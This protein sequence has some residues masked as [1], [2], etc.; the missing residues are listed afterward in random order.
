MT[1][2]IRRH[3]LERRAYVYVRQSTP[4]QVRNHLEGKKLHYALAKRA[5]ELGFVKVAVIDED[6]G[7]SGGGMQERPG[8]GRL[9]A[10]VCQGLAGAVFALEAS[11][12]ARNNRDWHHLVDLCALT[13]TLLVD[14]EGIYDP[15]QLNDR[16]LLGLK[17]TMAEFE[18]GLLRQ[19]AREA[20]EQKARR[21]F[22][23]WQ[24]PVG[25][26]R[27]DGQRIEKTPDRQVQQAITS[28]FEKFRQLGSARQATIWFREENIPL[29]RTEPSTSGREVVWELPVSGRIRQILKNPCYAGTFAYGKT[30]SRTVIEEGRAR[31]GSRSRKPPE[32]WKVLIV[33]HHSGYISWEEYL[34]NQQRLEANVV[35]HEGQTG[36]AA[37]LGAALLSG[38]LRC[39]HCGRKLQVVYSGT[40]GRVPRYVCRGDRGDRGSSRCLT[41]GSLRIDRAVAESVLT[42]I[43]PAGIEAA[44][45][46]Q[47]QI[48]VDDGEKRKALELALERAGYEEKRARRQYDAVDPENRLVAGEL[49]AR[50]NRALAQAAEAEAKLAAVGTSATLLSDEQKQ[51]LMALSEDLLTLWNQPEAPVPLKKRIL[52]TVLKEVIVNA[53]GEAPAYRVRLHWEGGVHTEL[54]VERNKSGQNRRQVGQPVVELVGELAKVCPDKAIAAILNRLGYK[55]GHELTWNASRV[56]GLRGYHEIE[57]FRKQEDWVTQE[58]AAR[59]LQVSNTVVKRLIREQV[60]PAKQVVK[61]APWIIRKD[62]LNLPAVVVQVDAVRRGAYR[63]PLIAIGQGKLPLE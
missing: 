40:G 47:E 35:A 20:F 59:A 42:A 9:L 25:F 2:K 15:R 38:L 58:E 22:A 34:E 49:E 5:E 8:F 36:G 46:F 52:R 24:V 14:S 53:D 17:G 19:R 45:R 26:I 1:E 61:F 63:P 28:V 50:W 48:S 31:Q 41:L 32:E 16:L 18:I 39:G 62:A 55:T 57:P 12:L 7:R 21:G 56:A 13:E 54:C 60:L 23:L 30:A 44:T 27:T 10:S 43:Q 29:P 51:L 33:G 37:K 3:H 11:R 4:Q 6:L